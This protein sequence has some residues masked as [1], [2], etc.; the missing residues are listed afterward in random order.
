MIATFLY[1]HRNS[2]AILL[3]II[4]G[5]W[6]VTSLRSEITRIQQYNTQLVAENTNVRMSNNQ[7]QRSIESTNRAVAELSKT[8]A[9]VDERFSELHTKVDRQRR[10][11]SNMLVEN[12]GP[13]PSSCEASIDYLVDRK[14]K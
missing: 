4:G 12:L 10:E 3:V 7:L 9:K 11:L 5:W 8:T 14:Y 1:A 13:V 2:I 6:Y